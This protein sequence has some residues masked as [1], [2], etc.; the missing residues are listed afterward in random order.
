MFEITKYET[1]EF[2]KKEDNLKD[3]NEVALMLDNV[4]T[5]KITDVVDARKFVVKLRG[6][7]QKQGKELREEAIATQKRV[8]AEENEYV[9]LLNPREEKFKQIEKENAHKELM[10]IRMNTLP[11]RK[12]S[13]EKIGDDVMIADQEI[14]EMD[15]LQFVEYREN[16]IKAKEEADR[17]KFEQ[18]QRIKDAQEVARKE[19]EEKAK[20]EAQEAIDKANREKEEAERKLK[21]EKESAEREAKEAEEKK[22]AEEKRLAKETDYKKWL[23]DNS[24]DKDTMKLIDTGTEVHMY[25]LVATYNK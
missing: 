4:D 9:A 8:L 10:K 15:D 6:L 22:K 17:V 12:D 2:K 14:L 3:L 16:R 19:A 5:T 7:I 11:I 20:R 1:F 24:F 18:E 21:E 25:K 23:T 13:L